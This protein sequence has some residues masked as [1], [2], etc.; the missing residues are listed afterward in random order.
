M[1]NFKISF[2]RNLYPFHLS[3]ILDVP[4]Y[5]GNGNKFLKVKNDE[6]GVEFSDLIMKQEYFND[7]EFIVENNVVSIKD[8]LSTEAAKALFAPIK[9]T[10]T[11]NQIT[12]FVEANYV[13]T[14]GNE[15]IKGQKVFTDEITF[16]N[17]VIFNGKV[18]KIDVQNS[19]FKDKIITLADNDGNVIPDSAGIEVYR[20]FNKPAQ[21]LWVEEDQK[22]KVGLDNLDAI[23]TQSEINDLQN[24]I[25]ENL[26]KIN[27][28]IQ[29]INTNQSN[30][31]T[32]KNQIAELEDALQNLK[33]D[34]IQ[35][36]AKAEEYFAKVDF[37]ESIEE[38]TETFILKKGENKI[39]LKYN[40]FTERNFSV[41]RNGLVQ[42]QGVDFDLNN[43]EIEFLF[44]DKNSDNQ[45]LVQYSYKKDS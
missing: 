5:S 7:K 8:Y 13:H 45:I 1:D 9:H 3:E 30:I 20:G 35:L 26:K 41:F 18:A 44:T 19:Y 42:I 23:A 25:T 39:T 15:F 11:K 36:K 16:N 6:S 17:N 38:I 37:L 24:Q 40:V 43:N 28:N 34:Y 4:S 22:W 2:F 27:Q 29:N 21:I 10:H 12:D 32:N 14:S 33:S 31:I